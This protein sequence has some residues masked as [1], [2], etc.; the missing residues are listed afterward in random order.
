[1]A[2]QIG[3]ALCV[4]RAQGFFV[5]VNQNE[6]LRR[7]GFGLVI[8]AEGKIMYSENL[9]LFLENSQINRAPDKVAGGFGEKGVSTI[10]LHDKSVRPSLIALAE[11]LRRSQAQNCTA[12]DFRGSV[13]KA[14]RDA[15]L[16]L[17]YGP[18]FIHGYPKGED[19]LD[20]LKSTADTLA[21][22]ELGP[23]TLLGFGLD[24]LGSMADL[25]DDP[26]LAGVLEDCTANGS[27]VMCFA[28][29]KRGQ[30]ATEIE[31]AR[32][33]FDRVF[34]AEK[35]SIAPVHATRV[36]FRNVSDR[37]RLDKSIYIYRGKTMGEKL[38]YLLR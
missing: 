12:M 35:A 9:N 6:T 16:D 5:D 25:A 34:V 10:Y 33:V 18:N 29:I 38:A 30:L 1:M 32:K 22:P 11:I 20:W 28:E 19:G 17:A 3:S 23:E 21:D 27:A 8:G 24:A 31:A 4:S 13:C 37:H 14:Y 2:V 15:A 26:E 7:L 36:Q